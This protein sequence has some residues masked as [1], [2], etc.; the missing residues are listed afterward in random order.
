MAY[1]EY[2]LAVGYAFGGKVIATLPCTVKGLPALWVS[3]GP[4]HP[5]AIFVLPPPATILHLNY[6]VAPRVYVLGTA[7]V[8]IVGACVIPIP[9]PPFF[10]II[11]LPGLTAIQIGTGLIPSL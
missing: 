6:L 3:V 9:T 11:T 4:P 1:H 10:A 2:A 7:L 8:P 5:G